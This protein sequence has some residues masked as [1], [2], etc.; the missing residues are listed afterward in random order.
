MMSYNK[1]LRLA[2]LL[3][4]LTGCSLWDSR[5]GE[6]KVPLPGT[7]VTVLAPAAGLETAKPGALKIA[8][9]A[10]AAV[11]A[12]PQAGGQPAH[13]ME[14]PALRDGVT[15]TWSASIGSGGGYRAKIT[16][17]PV[18]AGGRVFTMDS[19]AVVAG[20]D[21]ASGAQAWKTVTQ[22]EDDRSTNVGGGIVWDGGVVYAASGRADLVAIDAADGKVKWRARLP[23]PARS[24]PTI[25]N[26]TL[27]IA[28]IDDE[29]VAASAAD[30]KTVWTYQ[31][32]SADPAVL[33]LPAP[34][35]AD[36]LLFAGFGSGELA[37]LNPTSGAV[38]WTDSLAATRGRNSL[39]D[40]STVHGRAVIKSGR[41]FAVSM[42]QELVSLDLRSGRRLWER[43]VAAA[44]SPWVAG[45]WMFVSTDA[46]QITA[47]SLLDGQVAWVT[48]LDTFEDMTKK[49]TPI[50]W[51]GP[52][53]AG[54][55][56]IV[57]GTNGT[58]LSLSPY[59]GQ[60]LGTEKLAGA[61]SV[62]PVVA[63]GTLYI[64]T[65]NGAITAYR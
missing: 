31:G 20:F 22:G 33:G 2:L 28:L 60:I 25:V 46:G 42:G 49:K 32:S 58:A 11:E 29:M 8:L 15:Q 43:D 50:R 38:V 57:A 37:A 48:Q 45:D 21:A 55:R 13:D 5:F 61:A 59:T 47:I 7:R 41:A 52:V 56:L 12:W 65:D 16:A 6:E 24:A 34:A 23:A 10:P 44:E 35:F 36:G 18:V 53:L 62:A 9:P 39:A 26:G 51:L 3:P 1:V 27:F 54:D 40:L 63:G 14:H 19:D 30:G 64:V 4:L 17:S